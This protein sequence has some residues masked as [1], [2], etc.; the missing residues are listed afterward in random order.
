MSIKKKRSV[1]YAIPCEQFVCAGWRHDE[2]S[3]VRLSYL[4][5]STYLCQSCGEVW[6][7]EITPLGKFFRVIHRP[8]KRCND[9][10]DS[11]SILIGRLGT[12]NRER[13]DGAPFDLLLYEFLN[14]MEKYDA[15]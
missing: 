12:I 10:K 6:A 14:L 3:E 4:V 8:C 7:Q 11:G 5:N 1:N 13:W 15:K 2:Q 9:T